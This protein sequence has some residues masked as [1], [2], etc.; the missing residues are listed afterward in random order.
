M[1][2]TRPRLFSFPR[3]VELQHLATWTSDP[4]VQA[5]VTELVDTFAE[6][7]RPKTLPP[8]SLDVLTRGATH[9]NDQVRSIAGVRLSVATH[10]FPDALEAFERLRNH[11]DTGVRQTIEALVPNTPL[12]G[13]HT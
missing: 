5:T 10:Y 1:A 4:A 12:A 8:E 6:V 9:P 3:E 2:R 7:A 11:A 13:K